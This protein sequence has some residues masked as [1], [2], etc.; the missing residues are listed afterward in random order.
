MFQQ[1]LDLSI[2]FFTNPLRACDT[3]SKSIVCR[4][5]SSSAQAWSSERDRNAAL[6]LNARILVNALMGSSIA[7]RTP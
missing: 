5:T 7:E 3:T 6:S 4:S 1:S 2:L